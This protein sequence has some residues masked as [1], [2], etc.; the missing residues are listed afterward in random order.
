MTVRDAAAMVM[1]H[2]AHRNRRRKPPAAFQLIE[3]PEQ[4]GYQSTSNLS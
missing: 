4:N 1:K 3:D 2:I